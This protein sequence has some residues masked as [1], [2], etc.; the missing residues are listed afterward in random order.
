[1]TLR[2]TESWEGAEQLWQARDYSVSREA[3]RKVLKA[4]TRSLHR[5]RVALPPGQV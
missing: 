1:M 3:M 2:N 5:T 4:S